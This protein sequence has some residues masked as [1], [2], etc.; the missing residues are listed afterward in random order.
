MNLAELRK[1]FSGPT[2]PIATTWEKRDFNQETREAEQQR[3]AVRNGTQN[4]Q[5]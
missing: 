4:T 2:Q 1:L 5:S 3:D